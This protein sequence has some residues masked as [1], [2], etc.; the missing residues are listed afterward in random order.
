LDFED[1]N[2]PAADLDGYKMVNK[3]NVHVS[4]WGGYAD[5]N[6]DMTAWPASILV[7][8]DSP[9]TDGPSGATFAG[10]WSAE[11]KYSTCFAPNG[12]GDPNEGYCWGGGTGWTFDGCYDASAYGGIELWLK[13]SGAGWVDLGS[14]LTASVGQG[15]LCTENCGYSILVNLTDSWQH[16]SAGWTDIIGG[17]SFSAMDPSKITSVN[18]WMCNNGWCTQDGPTD[19]DIIYDDVRWLPK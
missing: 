18:I 15:G 2:I 9:G 19:L 5:S 7:R 11:F 14:P 10:N 16:I 13:G 17:P 3:D 6:P 8:D 4:L 12:S 1:P